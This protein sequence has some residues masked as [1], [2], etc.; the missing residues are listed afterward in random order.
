L[1]SALFADSFPVAVCDNIRINC[2]RLVQDELYREKMASKR[3]YFYRVRAQIIT[4]S[5]GIPIEFCILPGA[6]L[7]LQGLAELPL[8]LPGNVELFVDGGYNFYEWENYLREIEEM[9]LQ[10]TRR[11]NSKRGRKP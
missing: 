10:V 6:C 9:R 1:G 8:E 5:D 4:T 7:D 3:R 11:I 2:R